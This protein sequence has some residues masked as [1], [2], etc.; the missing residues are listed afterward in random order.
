M[1]AHTST[2]LSAL[3]SLLL[4][5]CANLCGNGTIERQE[6]CDDGAANS[7]EAPGACRT[8][9]LLPACGDGVADPSQACFETPRTIES[10]A[11][12]KAGITLDLNGDTLQ[13]LV[14]ANDDQQVQLLFGDGQGNFAQNLAPLALEASPHRIF[15][16]QINSDANPDLVVLQKTG[17]IACFVGRGNG[18]FDTAIFSA[19]QADPSDLI[20]LDANNDSTLDILY[21]FPRGIEVL[22]GD[23]FCNFVPIFATAT[24]LENPTSINEIDLDNDS[25]S[26]LLLTDRAEP[27][28]NRM[29]S[30]NNGTFFDANLTS[31]STATRILL[32]DLN[33]D[34]RSDV[35]GGSATTGEIFFAE[36]LGIGEFAPPSFLAAGDVVERLVLQDVNKDTVTDLVTSGGAA[37]SFFQGQGAG[38]FET[39][40]IFWA[41]TGV[42]ELLLNDVNADQVTDYLALG[43][44]GASIIDGRAGDFPRGIEL[45][46]SAELP[47]AAIPADLDGDDDPDLVVSTRDGIV[48]LTNNSGSFSRGASLNLAARPLSVAAADLDGDEDLELAVL[49][50]TGNNILLFTNEEGSF[51]ATQPEVLAVPPQTSAILLADSNADGT[52]DIVTVGETPA[53][54]RGAQG[55]F[56][57]PIFIPIGAASQA[58]SVDI[59][60]DG[61]VELVFLVGEE[62][63]ILQGEAV[64]ATLSVGV[65]SAFAFVNLDGASGLDLVTISQNT[66]GV[67]FAEDD[68]SFGEA[69]TIE[70]EEALQSIGTAD[71]DGDSKPELIVSGER[72][73]FVL[74]FETDK[75]VERQKIPAGNA[76][77]T[78]QSVDLNLDEIQELLFVSNVGVIVSRQLR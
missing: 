19:T 58:A 56:E 21:V 68:F 12:V 23:G 2:S 54:R 65:L 49:D 31:L 34:T 52:L 71:S 42:T 78:L 70:L 18:A 6:E 9:C 57:E 15:A 64:T 5:G 28:L 74:G 59:D 53:V 44:L 22:R 25:D 24:Q 43:S 17:D 1:K 51:D 10:S 30:N 14:L 62:L 46:L 61:S 7:D 8:S 11:P 55:N 45:L 35:I 72:L 60:Q 66:V 20:F 75:L 3:S 36:G 77:T 33:G 69:I 38:D 73:S 40:S 27:S 63:L 26:D 13:D 47:S 39:R 67:Q 16:Q 37:L 48:L 32:V 29:F 41:G 50:E 4:F 76:S